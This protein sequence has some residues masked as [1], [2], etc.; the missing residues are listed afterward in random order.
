MYTRMAR[1]HDERQPYVQD[2]LLE[3][4]HACVITAVAIEHCLCT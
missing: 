1:V 3:A 4:L 2:D